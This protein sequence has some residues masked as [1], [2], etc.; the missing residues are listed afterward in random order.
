M[1]RV[2]NKGETFSSRE[3]YKD[4]TVQHKERKVTLPKLASPAKINPSDA[5]FS[6]YTSPIEK[7]EGIN[8]RKDDKNRKDNEDKEPVLPDDTSSVEMEEDL[9]N[10]KDE[11]EKIYVEGKED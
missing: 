10:K 9:I 3:Y 4:R 5:E 8:D 1:Y 7:E 6:D 2:Q 11:S